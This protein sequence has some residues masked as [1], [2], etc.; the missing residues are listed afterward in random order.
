[1]TDYFRSVSVR[2]T[3]PVRGRFYWAIVEN[4]GVATKF[5]ELATAA[6]HFDTWEAA[7]QA[8][9]AELRRREPELWGTPSASRAPDAG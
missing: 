8:G 7:R 6:A 4:L 5:N 3:E 1:M 2:V 9:V